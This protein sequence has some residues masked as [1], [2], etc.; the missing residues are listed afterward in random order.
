MIW[1]GLTFDTSN[2]E[3]YPP[4]PASFLLAEAA[5]EVVGSKD[6]F[7]EVGTGSGIVAIAVA[8]FV[9]GAK[10]TASDVSRE[11]INVTNTN[12]RLN[13]VKIKTIVGDLYKPFQG[14]SFDVIAV[15][16][17]AVPYPPRKTWGLSG[18][19]TIATNGGLDGSNLVIKSISQA[20]KHLKPKGKLLLLLP[21][22]SNVKKAYEELIKNYASVSRLSKKEVEFFPVT[23]GKPTKALLHHIHTLSTNRVIELW[24]KN[25]KLYSRVSVI[26]AIK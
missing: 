25:K 4:K 10:V 18:G 21:H 20:V 2:P 26:Q 5:L 8:K 14:K 12:A 3:V 6:N 11:A 24:R 13:G 17:P 16:P 22:W 7:L 1:K 9:N 15:H 19:M 23:E